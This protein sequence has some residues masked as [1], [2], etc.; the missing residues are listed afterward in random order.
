MFCIGQFQ[1]YDS[2]FP[3]HEGQHLDFAKEIQDVVR[4]I[5][6]DLPESRYIG[7][8]W[9]SCQIKLEI[10]AKGGYG[11]MTSIECY[12][13]DHVQMVVDIIKKYS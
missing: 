8:V 1:I 13:S 12:D 4:E 6:K 9:V 10:G 7:N 3:D 5:N 11:R 2:Q